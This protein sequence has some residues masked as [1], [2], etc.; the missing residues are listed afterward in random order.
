MS[1]RFVLLPFGFS[2]AGGLVPMFAFLQ[3]Q[4][5]KPAAPDRLPRAQGLLLHPRRLDTRVDTSAKSG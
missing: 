1:I 5:G 4:L 3:A 2:R